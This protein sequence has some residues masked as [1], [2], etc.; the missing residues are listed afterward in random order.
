MAS[1]LVRMFLLLL[2]VHQSVGLFAEQRSRPGRPF[3]LVSILPLVNRDTA[4][5][6]TLRC[7]RNMDI[8]TEMAHIFR[9]RIVK[10]S[11]SGWDLIAEKRDNED[12][13][14]AM[15]GNLTASANVTGSVSNA[16]LETVWADVNKD[17]FGL[18]MCDVMGLDDSNQVVVEAST[19]VDILESELPTR[20]FESLSIKARDLLT[21]LK[22]RIES[23]SQFCNESLQNVK[24]KMSILMDI[25][26]SAN[27]RITGLDKSRSSIETSNLRL[28]NKM[29]SMQ[30][31]LRNV[32]SRLDGL[33][34]WPGG[35]YA[36]LQPK[37]GCPVDLA[38]F[39]GTHKFHKIHTE[40][41][42]SS[43]YRDSYT[44]DAFSSLTSFRT[45][46]RNF[47]SIEFC[48]V[49]RQFN[50][51][52]WPQGSFCINK[53]YHKS[54]PG[55]FSS[56]YVRFD[57][58]DK[59]PASEGRNN[60]ALSD[61]YTNP[62][63]HFC[64]QKTGPA[65]TPVQLPTDS[66]FLLYRHG[67]MCQAVKDM[68]VSTQLLIFNTQDSGNSDSVNGSYPDVDVDPG[69]IIKFHLCYYTKR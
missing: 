3:Q 54:C 38:F 16:F 5:S 17:T 62:K 56:G 60:V 46:S 41:Q 47:V 58:E 37:T 2:I 69:S 66:P 49:T 8:R 50:T 32:E 43:D 45:D 15:V 13:T 44:S 57:T 40:S 63:L 18:F 11:A 29:D 27:Y 9:M 31:S 6:M 21:A 52:P 20:Y 28:Q 35:F 23:E 10:K 51:V 19:E 42:D 39:G 33:V 59:I 68:D 1:G 26:T 55:G 53:L 67:G 24:E 48:E 30:R 61:Y 65:S 25:Q 36:L 4:S 22:E 34:Q 64:C 7:E 14:T 12:K